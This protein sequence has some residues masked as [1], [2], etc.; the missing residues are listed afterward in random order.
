MSTH[1]LGRNHRRFSVGQSAG[2]G[3]DIL[4]NLVNA[5]P[6][7]GSMNDVIGTNNGIAEGGLTYGTGLSGLKAFSGNGS[8]AY[9]QTSTT[10]ANPQTF[11]LS[12]WFNTLSSGPIISFSNTQAPSSNANDRFLGVNASGNIYFYV[13][14]TT[15]NIV[16]SPNTYANGNWHHV[17]VTTQ[18]GNSILYVDGVNV[19]SMAYG[20]GY[21]INPGYWMLNYAYL[22]GQGI[23]GNGYFNGLTQDIRY[24]NVFLSAGQIYQLY[25]N[26]PIIA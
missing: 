19:A 10:Y 16:Y 5:W 1:I 8:T 7:N 26:K 21:T 2:I 22:S 3:N 12:A 20:G 11:T 25:L 17:A 6:E 13:Y 14:I 18:S 24:Y 9:A 23:T 4:T 15:Y